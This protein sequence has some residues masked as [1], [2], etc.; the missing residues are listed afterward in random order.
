MTSFWDDLSGAAKV[1]WVVVAFW[2]FMLFMAVL[3]SASG[4]PDP[5]VQDPPKTTYTVPLSCYPDNDD[6]QPKL[7]CDIPRYS[8]P[9]PH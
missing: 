4:P 2:L 5:V 6:Q 1:A 8:N 9:T 3:G 7:V